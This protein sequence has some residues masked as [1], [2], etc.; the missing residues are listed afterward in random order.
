VAGGAVAWRRRMNAEHGARARGL[1]AC[2]ARINPRAIVAELGCRD[3]QL[4]GRGLR[5]MR[6]QAG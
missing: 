6:K 4:T 2:E 1:A 5:E 3:T